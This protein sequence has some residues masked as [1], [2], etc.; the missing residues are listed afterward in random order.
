MDEWQIKIVNDMLRDAVTDA[1]AELPGE[2]IETQVR[3]AALLIAETCAEELAR[4]GAAP[5]WEARPPGN[6]PIAQVFFDLTQVNEP[7]QLRTAFDT[8]DGKFDLIEELTRRVKAAR[9]LLS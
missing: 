7:K 6:A 2:S 1:L 9:G 4:V 8:T 5:P 3:A